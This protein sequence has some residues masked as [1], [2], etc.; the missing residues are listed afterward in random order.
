MRPSTGKPWPWSKEFLGP[1]AG[2]K[3]SW[4]VHNGR[5]FI[6]FM[7]QIRDAFFDS[8][9]EAEKK[10]AEGDALWSEWWGELHA[11]PFNADCLAETWSEHDCSKDPQIVPPVD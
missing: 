8:D 6:N 2:S 9:V 7:P 3:D 4:K 10:I 5:L 11:G 1:P